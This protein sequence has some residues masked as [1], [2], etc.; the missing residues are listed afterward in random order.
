MRGIVRKYKGFAIKRI[1]IHTVNG[2][3]L[4]LYEV[5]KE[6]ASDVYYESRLWCEGKLKDAKKWI[7]EQLKE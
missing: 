5:Y 7:D 4:P 3:C 6:N 1:T 2:A